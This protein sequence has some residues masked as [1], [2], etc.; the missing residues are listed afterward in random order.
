PTPAPNGGSTLAPETP[1]D[2]QKM[3]DQAM[4]T[5][6]QQ[7]ATMTPEQKLQAVTMARQQAEAVVKAS[8]GDD[9]TAK[10]A[11]DQAEASVRQALGL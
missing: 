5:L 3:L 7:A 11:G 4:E 10:A 8:G 9:A 1:A 2:A 6:K